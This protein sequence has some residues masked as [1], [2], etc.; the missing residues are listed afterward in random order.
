MYLGKQVEVVRR[1]LVTPLIKSKIPFQFV[2]KTHLGVSIH[3][4]IPT[5]QTYYQLSVVRVQYNWNTNNSGV[6]RL[7][8]LSI[9]E[10]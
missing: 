4:Q 9:I 10:S 8:L 5:I 7:F 1:G 3:F 6:I 2:M